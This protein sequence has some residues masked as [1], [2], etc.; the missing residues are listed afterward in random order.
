MRK[1]IVAVDG[2]N[3]KRDTVEFAISMANHLHGHLVGLFLND[4]TYHSYQIYT[5]GGK[6]I[7]SDS[8][9]KKAEQK[10]TTVRQEA[11][12]EFSMAC[13]LHQIPYSI[14]EN[15]NIALPELIH[16][17]IYADLLII[18]SGEQFTNFIESKPSLF[19]HDLLETVK[20]PV[21]LAP[22]QFTTLNKALLLYDGS[23]ASVI[24]IKSFCF[25]SEGFKKD[26]A[27]EVLSVKSNSDSLHLPDN[28]LMKEYL[29]RHYP[30]AT[31][32]ICKGEADKK[33]PA[34]L[35]KEDL[36]CLVVSGAYNRGYISRW[37]RPSMADILLSTVKLPLFINHIGK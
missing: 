14:H 21:M 19:I 25:I 12:Q 33:I 10:D 7:M 31:Y 18:H 13:E 5:S 3:Y 20:C 22:D 24:A 36:G 30:K 37:F 27:V 35:R 16:E 15:R 1:I 2:L 17:S 11:V 26:L 28:K 29:K 8:E 23:P 9:I 4:R 6:K 32:T 34:I